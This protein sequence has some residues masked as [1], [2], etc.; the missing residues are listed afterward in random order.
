V[1]RIRTGVPALTPEEDSF[2]N[3][4]HAEDLARI[5]ALALFRGGNGRAYNVSDDAPEKIGDW[6]DLIADA[7]GLQRVE[8]VSRAELKERVSPLLWS[9]LRES[10]Q[11]SNARLKREFQ[12]KLRFPSVREGLRAMGTL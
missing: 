1:E 4:I 11:L 12:I 9:F 2:S 10:R 6:F 3:H 8:R 5:S 7:H